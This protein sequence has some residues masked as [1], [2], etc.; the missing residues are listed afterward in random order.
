MPLGLAVQPKT[1]DMREA[2][3]LSIV[4]S[5]SAWEVKHTIR[6]PTGCTQIFVSGGVFGIQLRALTGADAWR[7][8]GVAEFRTR[9][10]AHAAADARA[11]RLRGATLHSRAMLRARLILSIGR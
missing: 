8:C 5:V 3:A 10:R 1:G 9:L 7:S 4:T 6:R 2:P 11:R